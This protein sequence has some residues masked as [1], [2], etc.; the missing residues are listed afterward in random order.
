MSFTSGFWGDRG[1]AL[2]DEES[3]SDAPT[4]TALFAQIAVLSVL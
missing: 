3:S 2:V 4:S 1:A